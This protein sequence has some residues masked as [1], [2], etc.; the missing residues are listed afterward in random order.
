MGILGALDLL[1]IVLIPDVELYAGAGF[2]RILRDDGQGAN[3]IHQSASGAAMQRLI[4]VQEPIGD[5]ELDLHLAVPHAG[6]SHPVKIR[7]ES[8]AWQLGRVLG[9][10]RRCTIAR[11][12]RG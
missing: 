12:I 8:C 2:C 7:V 6:D 11:G 4:G 10:L 5:L 9:V 3:K 1:W